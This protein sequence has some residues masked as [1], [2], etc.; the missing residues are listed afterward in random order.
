MREGAATG[1]ELLR[2]REKRKA[3]LGRE[4]ALVHEHDEFLHGEEDEETLPDEKERQ[5]PSKEGEERDRE[6]DGD[7]EAERN[8][9]KRDDNSR[10]RGLCEPSEKRGGDGKGRRG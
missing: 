9:Q 6:L 2:L 5:S 10:T 8:S 4:G 7:D 3:H 1:R